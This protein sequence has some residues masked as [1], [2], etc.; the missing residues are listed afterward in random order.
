MQPFLIYF[1]VFEQSLRIFSAT[2]NFYK[3][4]A[5][6]NRFRWPKRPNWQ[7]GI[8]NLLFPPMNKCYLKGFWQS[9][10]SREL[11]DRRLPLLQFWSSMFSSSLNHSLKK[12]F[13]L[14]NAATARSSCFGCQ[15]T[16]ASIMVK[17]RSEFEIEKITKKGF[18][19][20]GKILN[21]NKKQ[22]FVWFC[23]HWLTFKLWKGLWQKKVG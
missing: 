14:K 12:I 9:T 3:F 13:L 8:I 1:P 2:W 7:A 4:F 20:Y 18:F 19:Y 5:R 11:R 17:V 15:N 21:K 22:C 23:I 6:K 10:V 16:P